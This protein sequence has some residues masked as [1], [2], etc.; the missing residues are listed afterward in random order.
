MNEWPLTRIPARN[1]TLPHPDADLSGNA[2]IEQDDFLSA[3]Q[4]YYKRTH[5]RP[6]FWRGRRNRTVSQ[7]FLNPQHE[8]IR[9]MMSL[10]LDFSNVHANEIDHDATPKPTSPTTTSSARLSKDHGSIMS[11][12]DRHD[13]TP[14][15]S[16]EPSEPS[17]RRKS[18][19]HKLRR[20]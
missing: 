8:A 13:E 14:P 5:S 17:S 6:H 10:S 4:T 9:S 18:L 12:K 19:F 7:G 20:R 15:S 11:G 16:P 3:E 2:C 1:T